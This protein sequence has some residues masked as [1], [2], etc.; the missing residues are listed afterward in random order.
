MTDILPGK[1]VPLT[2]GL[3]SPRHVFPVVPIHIVFFPFNGNSFLTLVVVIITF[4]GN[5]RT[6]SVVVM[7]HLCAQASSHSLRR[8]LHTF[9]LIG[10]HL[11]AIPGVS[12]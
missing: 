3:K 12:V 10:A 7:L 4:P 8:A 9:R 1:Y 11:R 5:L 6:I 2:G